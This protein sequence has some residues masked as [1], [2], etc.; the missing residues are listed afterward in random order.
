MRSSEVSRRGFVLAAATT[1]AL[2]AGSP[3][4]AADAPAVL[5]PAA[6]ADIRE[7][8]A[9]VPY[10]FDV[11]AFQAV[12]DQRY[13][14][15]LIAVATSFEAG[16]TQ[17]AHLKNALNAYAD[18]LGFNAGP[19]SLH[20]ACVYYGGLGYTLALDDAMWA[21]YPLATMVDSEMH[22]ANSAYADRAKALKSNLNATDYRALVADH[23]VSF[24]VCNNAFSGFAYKV[25]RAITRAETAVTRAQVVAIHDEMIAHFLPGTTLVPAGVAALNAAQEAH[26]TFLPE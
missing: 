26:F 10:H 22:G 18:P 1:A 25:A 23:G 24:F 9:T 12:L 17:F 11:A 16:T 8:A 5:S 20:A 7:L 19:K 21:K 3:A 2:A 4:V 6:V 13:D 15:R 14:H